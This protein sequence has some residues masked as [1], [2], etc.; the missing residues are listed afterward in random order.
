MSA[1]FAPAMRQSGQMLRW[2]WSSPCALSSNQLE[3]TTQASNG[4]CSASSTVSKAMVR[5][6]CDRCLDLYL[7]RGH[8]YLFWFIGG[9]RPKFCLG[10]VLQ[11]F[12]LIRVR[13]DRWKLKCV[14]T[15]VHSITKLIARETDEGWT[16]GCR[17]R[18]N[19]SSAGVLYLNVPAI[20]RKC[21][22]R[23][24]RILPPAIQL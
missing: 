6:P 1:V 24:M 18:N 12:L 7:V 17:F 15:W 14:I 3:V 10:L 23:E 21:I 4:T 22:L 13:E 11:L 16:D 5:Q 8:A 20:Y 9:W 2:W 19:N